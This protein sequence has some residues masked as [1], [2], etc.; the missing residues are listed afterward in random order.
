MGK[1][2]WALALVVAACGGGDEETRCEDPKYGDGTCDAVTSCAAPDIDCFTTFATQ[3]EAQAWYATT[4]VA[5]ERPPV[6]A[7]EPRFARMQM[8][9]DQGWEAYQSVYP[10][11]DLKNFKVPLVLNM[12]NLAN[13]FV[14]SKDAKSGLAIMVS[15][16]FLDLNAPDEEMMGLVMHELHHAIE[17]HT[18]PDIRNSFNRYYVAPP[19][20]EPFGYEQT[21]N[22]TARALIEEWIEYGDAIGYLD[23]AE[24]R[25]FPFD[26]ELFQVFSKRL[27]MQPATTACNT[28]R[29]NF[30]TLRN[31]VIGLRDPISR[32]VSLNPSTAP[33]AFLDSM[34]ALNTN[35]F[36]GF[37]M[38][39]VD[40][41]AAHF[42]ITRAQALAAI[43]ADVQPMVVAPVGY[44]QGVLNFHLALR[45]KMRDIEARFMTMTGQ[46]WTR[47]RYYSTEEA[48]DDASVP[49][50]RAMG[51]PPDGN[52]RM[53]AK[54]LPGVE[55]P[56]RALVTSGA[57]IHYG[58]NI[59]DNHHGACWRS[60]HIDALAKS[61]KT[62]LHAPFVRGP[63]RQRTL[64]SAPLREY[65][66]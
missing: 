47:A 40:V 26:G 25:G 32:G 34:N 2:L 16:K 33:Q 37:T 18:H 42:M 57:P 43:P 44:M 48:A 5:A 51:L 63:E 66:H 13:A 6:P 35:C 15:L 62:P 58:E 27:S 19:G 45:T 23:D 11:G 31:M 52:G 65:S 17:L 39:L 49:V 61:G 29:M 14:T 41:I 9:I 36:A 12:E 53:V 50:L 56:C 54:L 22:P 64:F 60:G 38:D 30:T 7:T 28:A 24:L 21:D 59:D 1:F 8:L 10:V 20:S 3:A 55:E 46:P 4:S